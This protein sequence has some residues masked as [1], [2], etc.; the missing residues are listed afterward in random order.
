MGRFVACFANMHGTC[1]DALAKLPQ[2]DRR[3]IYGL[4]KGLT[5]ALR[6]HQSTDVASRAAGIA[7]DGEFFRFGDAGLVV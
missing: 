5:A 4:D 2:K 7:T 6:L 3:H 1:V